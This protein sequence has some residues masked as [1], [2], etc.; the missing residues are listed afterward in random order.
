MSDYAYHQYCDN[1]CSNKQKSPT[2]IDIIIIK[3]SEI[4]FPVDSTGV[5]ELAVTKVHS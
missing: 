1:S 5:P 2:V 4:E 3:S